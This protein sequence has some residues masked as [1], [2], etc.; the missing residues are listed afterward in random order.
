MNRFEDAL[1]LITGGG[2]GIGLASAIRIAQEGGKVVLIG[3]NRNKLDDALK[4]I[5]GTGHIAE[6][7]DCTDEKSLNSFLR[8]VK[9][10]K[11]PF[12]AA[13]VSAG[14]HSVR[15]FVI[16]NTA[17]FEEL[18]R[19]NVFSAVATAKAFSK[20]AAAEGGAL[21]FISSA[22]AVKGGGAVSAYSASKAALLGLTRSL[23]VELAKNKIRVNVVLP[24][25]V[26]TGMT[27]SFFE[28]LESK[29]IQEIENRHLLGLGT[30]QDVA[31]AIAFLSSS[32]SKW[33]TGSEFSVDGGFA[34]Q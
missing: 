5:P 34:C 23:A 29:Q 15:P 20:V 31:S 17:H 22:A 33:I 19:G 6:V 10:D 7:L 32:D 25:V 14:I 8:G 21:T 1:V 11:G 13:V 27:K 16:T 18:F 26:M 24:G 3:R 28:S 4:K 9:Q 2:S 12:K 30:P